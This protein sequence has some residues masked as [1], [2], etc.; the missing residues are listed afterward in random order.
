MGVLASPWVKKIFKGAH[1]CA[2]LWPDLLYITNL[3]KDLRGWCRRWRQCKSPRETPILRLLKS[4][5]I[6]TSI[7]DFSFN[8][9]SQT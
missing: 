4:Y 6:F 7:D 5:D 2:K 8:S 9:A 1:L 3:V